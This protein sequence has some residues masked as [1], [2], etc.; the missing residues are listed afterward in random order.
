MNRLRD[1]ATRIFSKHWPVFH[2]TR[3]WIIVLLIAVPLLAV[4]GGLLAAHW[5][6]RYSK[7][8]SLLEDMFA[9]RVKVGNYHRIYFPHPGFV[10]TQLT[11]TS[12]DHP[13]GQ[14]LGTVQ[15][16]F[17]ESYWSDLLLLRHRV[18]LVEVTRMH[19]KLPEPGG[20]KNTQQQSA[21]Q[22]SNAS[23][24]K[25]SGT[26]NTKSQQPAN[27]TSNRPAGEHFD[28]PETPIERLTLHDTT[29]DILRGDGAGQYRFAIRNLE[30]L[31]L[32]KGHS[33][34]YSVDMENALPAAHISADG[35]IGPVNPKNIGAT[36]VSGRFTFTELKLSDI[37]ELRGKL[38]GSGNFKGVMSN[39]QAQSNAK[40]P[41]FAVSNG[42]RTPL[43]GFIHCTVNALNGDVFIAQVQVQSSETVIRANGQVAGSPKVTHLEISM[44]QGR[45][46]VVLRPFMHDQVPILGPATLHAN[47]YVA[48]PGP[49]FLQRLVLKG[50]FDA[51][52]EIDTD[53][54]QEKTLT[55]FSRRQLK[56][57][58]DPP[59]P[60]PPDGQD[61]LSSIQG[62][63]T[64]RKGIIS[65]PGIIFQ[66]P[67]AS[68]NLHGTFS[69]ENE[70]VHLVGTLKM[71][72]PISHAT[73]GW[74]AVV[75]KF[76]QPFFHRKHHQ[77]S[78][79]PIA[80]LGAPGHY[81]VTQ[82]VLK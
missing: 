14:P 71:E 68:A 53:P 79:I 43:Q 39:I 11:L 23:P 44:D 60:P 25:S 1:H 34:R 24:A 13:D 35:S 29:L 22:H 10:A 28:G 16:M 31:G 76:L 65:T 3:R 82:N 78:Q 59:A 9:C 64:I 8:H 36:P 55:S 37:G 77:G 6:F 46:E 19:L 47:V 18:R 74:K 45:A 52:A 69:L 48:P 26:Q 2:L 38:G 67:G 56:H 32:Q 41:D 12:S 75:L 62:P 61:A 63:A 30:L 21:Q 15:T 58:Q 20:S 5:P 54:Q 81:K 17:A 42:Q 49:P 27:Q 73:T 70:D 7:I 33:W 72:A 50:H 51:P 66:L 4:G 40:I 80:V 57:A